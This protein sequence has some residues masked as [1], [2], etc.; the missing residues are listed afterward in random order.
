M[1]KGDPEKTGKKSL[2]EVELQY[3]QVRRSM[4][5]IQEKYDLLKK[6]RENL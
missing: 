2:K 1:M 5:R 6:L 3:E 4:K